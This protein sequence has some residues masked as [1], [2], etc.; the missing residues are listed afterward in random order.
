MTKY[1]VTYENLDY[2]DFDGDLPDSQHLVGSLE[3][4]EAL[5]LVVALEARAFLEDG[6]GLMDVGSYTIQLDNT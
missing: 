2:P 6:S 5:E 4:T 1:K 3:L